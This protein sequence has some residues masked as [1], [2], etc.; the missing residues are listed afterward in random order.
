LIGHQGHVASP[1]GSKP[2]RDGPVS[3][4]AVTPGRHRGLG[5]CAPQPLLLAAL[6]LASSCL[7]GERTQPVQLEV[8]LEPLSLDFGTVPV[9][10]R[11]SRTVTATNV[12]SADLSVRFRTE[13][14]FDV[15]AEAV[16][17]GG[18]SRQWTV[19]FTPRQ[20]GVQ[21]G[22]LE[23]EVPEA[24]AEPRLQVVELLGTAE[25]PRACDTPWPCWTATLV[26]GA[27]RVEPRPDE[28]PCAS[29]CLESGR[30]SAGVCVGLSRTCPDDGDAC[31]VES[32]QLGAGCVRTP[33]Q[34][35]ASSDP[36]MV[37]TCDSAQGCGLTAASDG[38]W[39]G[40]NDCALAH[41]CIAGQCVTRV[42][43]EGSQC[44]A[45]SPCQPTGRCTS[46]SCQRPDAGDLPRR[47]LYQSADGGA[48]TLLSVLD[49]QDHLYWVEDQNLVS[50]D[51][52]GA[53][54]FITGLPGARSARELPALS[55][56]GHLIMAL[57]SG[58]LASFATAT[59][60]LEWTFDL[61][62]L[63]SALVC[64]EPG[65]QITVRDL[66]VDGLGQLSVSFVFDGVECSGAPAPRAFVAALGSASGALHWVITRPP[67]VQVASH[68]VGADGTVYFSDGK[69]WQ[70][71]A[72]RQG[73]IRWT[74][75]A[76]GDL[77]MASA[78]RI[79]EVDLSMFRLTLV[80]PG[81]GG[82]MVVPLAPSLSGSLK[83]FTLPDEQLVE[84]G[85]AEVSVLLSTQAN[86]D[87]LLTRQ[88]LDGGAPRVSQPVVPSPRI[89]DLGSHFT[90][91]DGAALALVRGTPLST[92]AEVAIVE[93]SGAVRY[94]CALQVPQPFRALLLDSLLVPTFQFEPTQIY[95][96]D[97][98]GVRPSSVLWAAPRRN[99][100]RWNRGL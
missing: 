100:Q 5:R 9:G 14:P 27:C 42:P 44:G 53:I 37:A 50:A 36:C 65:A 91:D 28:T 18:E 17:L 49:E 95:G 23:V 82:G 16:L 94:R 79:V 20:S 12:S 31:T 2:L 97:L 76:Q 40:D 64:F 96:Y 1:T 60:A 98:P 93:R 32:C 73:G 46:G 56:D 34:C 85:P 70:S 61:G 83:I 55:W 69:S 86:P 81:T 39:C 51:R 7:C 80:D 74:R 59:G 43:P 13:P 63:G 90:L 88:P 25:E 8:W 99:F 10:V 87:L 52:T 77:A 72:T 67:G 66:A 4:P 21:R 75:P 89:F 62:S 22:K 84:S 68:L 38:T 24:T 41:V 35:P 6:V 48:V 45:P 11:S 54:R 47:L 26:D 15:A 19:A 71:A 57:D 92:G 78:D 33:R 30:C 58:H 3:L 29:A